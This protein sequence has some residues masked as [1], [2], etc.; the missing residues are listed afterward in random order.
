MPGGAPAA[1]FPRAALTPKRLK[2]KEVYGMAVREARA[3]VTGLAAKPLRLPD[4]EAVCESVEAIIGAL[5]S[6]P[7]AILAFVERSTPEDFLPGHLT[8]STILSLALAQKM[9][10]AKDL[11]RALGVGAFLHDS[12]ENQEDFMILKAFLHT[13]NAESRSVIENILIQTHER[14]SGNGPKGL[15]SADISQEAQII[16][17]CHE[18]ESQSH[19]RPDRARRLSHEV[20]RALIEQAGLNFDGQILKKLW[21]TLSLFPP[22]SYVKLS[23]GEI[24]RVVE[25]HADDPIKP[26]VQI[27]AGPRGE[28]IKEERILDLAQERGLSIEGAADECSVKLQDPSLHLELKAQ[29]WWME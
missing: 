9:G 26:T 16:G 2:P 29:K 6:S 8:N 15:K 14:I 23:S 28:R 7:S 11:Q 27:V 18:F 5:E 4:L 10:L 12:A 13:L 17:L 24:A 19:P 25:L 21:E 20:L 22:G 1:N 3:L